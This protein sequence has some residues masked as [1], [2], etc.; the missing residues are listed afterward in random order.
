ME[1]YNYLFSLAL[2]EVT[3]S[4][5]EFSNLKKRVEATKMDPSE[6]EDCQVLFDVATTVNGLVYFDLEKFVENQIYGINEAFEDLID[7]GV[8]D[9][10]VLTE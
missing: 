10:I 4:E 9:K 3:F 5:E 1:T 6:R 8:I 7:Q 2:E